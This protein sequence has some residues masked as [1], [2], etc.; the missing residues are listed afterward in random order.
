MC[1]FE[2]RFRADEDAERIMSTFYAFVEQ[3]GQGVDGDAHLRRDFNGLEANLLVRLWS[4]EAMDAF[5]GELATPPPRPQK[6]AYE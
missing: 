5:L 6:T 4:A 3:H 1:G 2:T